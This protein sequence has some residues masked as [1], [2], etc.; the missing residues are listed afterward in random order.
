VSD[1]RD[2]R[3]LET[4]FFRAPSAHNT[5]PWILEYRP[6]R[7]ELH[8]DPAR[9]L[10]AGDPTRRDLLLSLGALVE[11]V[12]ITASSVGMAIEFAPAFEAEPRRVGTFRRSSSPYATPFTPDDLSRRQTSRGEYAPG[13]L[14]GDELADAR[15]QVAGDAELHELSTHELVDL[16]VAAELHLYDSPAIVEE[17]RSWLR[18]S[19][20]HPRYELDG[21]TYECLGLAPVEATAVALLLRQPVY[22]LVHLLRLHRR[23]IAA[24]TSLL[25]RD[26]SALVLE[27][28]AETPEQVLTHGRS[29][30][31]AWLTLARQGLHTHP[32]SQILDYEATERELA[33]Q[34]GAAAEH[35]L[36]CVFR[37]GRS[38]PPP[39]SSR[40]PAGL[41][42]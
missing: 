38:G 25:E 32:L 17:L 13:R 37:A 10:P 41:E 29:L 6:D 2:L 30:L 14:T 7:V 19:R 11:A 24:T 42:S 36:L 18:L 27:G 16:N 35:R 21:L 9:A 23:F 4:Q 40:R 34:I 26:G 15:S 33:A 28:S 39:R 3:R 12:L 1:L 20:R 31:R 5:Q 8:F 22:R